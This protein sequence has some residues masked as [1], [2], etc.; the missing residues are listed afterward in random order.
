MQMAQFLSVVSVVLLGAIGWF[1][2]EFIGR[3]IR[4]FFDL[5]RETR[6]QML[7]LA[8]V[9]PVSFIDDDLRASEPVHQQS[10]A[11][12]LNVEKTFRDLGTQLIA[13]G[14]SEWAASRLVRIAGFDPI[15]AGNALIGFSNN[16]NDRGAERAE[17]RRRITEALRFEH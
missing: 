16:A 10:I 2:L 17:F 5:R 1:A 8:N 11:A 14:E 6:R 12:V 3:P 13:F 7:F 15:A 9:P 4:S